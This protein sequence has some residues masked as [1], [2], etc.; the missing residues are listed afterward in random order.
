M[1]Y[2]AIGYFSDGC[3]ESF[4]LSRP[5]DSEDRN[6]IADL[7]CEEGHCLKENIDTVLVVR[8]GETVDGIYDPPHVKHH[9]TGQGGDFNDDEDEAG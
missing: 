5:T 7:L 6:V 3:G 2:L 4:T 8:N 1:K 9:W